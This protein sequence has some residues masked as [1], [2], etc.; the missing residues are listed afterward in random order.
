[1]CQ[2]LKSFRQE[3]YN[4]VL[5]NHN[6]R[7]SDYSECVR[8]LQ[9]HG[10]D[11]NQAKNGAYVYKHHQTKIIIE[12]KGSQ[13]DYNS[14]LD[15][16][17]AKGKSNKECVEYLKGLGFSYGQAKSAVYSYRKKRGLI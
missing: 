4:R 16:Y 1:M 17:G 2:N 3:E 8:V 9:E 6:G 5:N 13:G 7:N 14:L 11:Y 10:A 12:R 15:K